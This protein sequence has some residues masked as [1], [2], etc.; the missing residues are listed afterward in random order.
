MSE[1]ARGGLVQAHL[2]LLG[3]QQHSPRMKR[4]LSFQSTV[5]PFSITDLQ[6]SGCVAAPACSDPPWFPQRP[7]TPIVTHSDL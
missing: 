6:A 2:D 3:M 7:V 5:V 1:Q 4:A